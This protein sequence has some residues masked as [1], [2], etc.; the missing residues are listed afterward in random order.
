[1]NHTKIEWCDFTWNPLRTVCRH[2]CWY[3]YA[4][5]IIQRF[6]HDYRKQAHLDDLDGPRKMKKPARIFVGSMTDIFGEWVP[7]DTIE[8][9][10]AAAAG[11]PQHTFIFLTK[12]PHR[13]REFVGRIPANCWL[14][15]TATDQA[16]WDNAYNALQLD[17]MLP[18][19]IKFVSCE[20]LLRPIEPG[21]FT[22]DWI[23]IGALTGPRSKDYQ[24]DPGWIEY[25]IHYARWCGSPIFLKDNLGWPEKIQEYPE[26]R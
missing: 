4:A 6:G 24:P 2:R 23:I 15:A 8:R 16:Q 13:Y 11:Y 18:G 25:L 5:G 14:G 7:W 9:I 19:H 3:C 20:P 1:M 22:P 26:E 21:L 10:F 12:N 17:D